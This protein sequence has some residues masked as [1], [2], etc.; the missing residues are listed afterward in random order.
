MAATLCL[1][2]RRA[3]IAHIEVL[4]TDRVV[5]QCE[6]ANGA[7]RWVIYRQ[8]RDFI[9]LHGHYRVASVYLRGDQPLLPEFPKTSMR[10]AYFC[11]PA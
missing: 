6:Y 10:L 11:L 4:L 3:E 5:C 2:L 9:S 7:A 8:L 1:E